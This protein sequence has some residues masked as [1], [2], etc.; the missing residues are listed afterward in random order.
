VLVTHF[1]WN[2]KLSYSIPH[3]LIPLSLIPCYTILMIT[4]KPHLFD[5][6]SPEAEEV[7]INLLRQAPPWRK[8]EMVGELHATVKFLAAEG[9][10]RRHP[11]ASEKE[12]KRHLA[13]ILL[14]E[15][16]AAKAYGSWETFHE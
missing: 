15:E 10:R 13:D 9:V 2:K 16:L 5:D 11:N 7:L 3:K 8:M 12:V 1:A 4:N 6:T 14:G